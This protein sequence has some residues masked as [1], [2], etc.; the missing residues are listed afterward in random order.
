MSAIYTGPQ[1]PLCGAPLEAEKLYT[2]LM[3]CPS[4]EGAFEATLFQPRER[5]HAAIAAV[6]ETPEGV[7]ASCA[8]HARNAAVTSCQRCGLFIC[9]LCD[10]SLDGFSYC[11]SCFDF[12]RR[13][14]TLQT[15][16]RDWARMSQSA[17]V[18]GFFCMTMFIPLGPLAV[19]WGV[20]GLRQRRA[21]ERSPAGV[22]VAMTFGVLETIGFIAAIG[23]VVWAIMEGT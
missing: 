4:C 21:E 22:I 2:G 19:W 17:A 6:T 7:A 1:C 11:P 9:A 15:R 5:R 10:M 20:K 18:L 12:L 16:Y 3:E 13:E 8:N 23:L 14:G